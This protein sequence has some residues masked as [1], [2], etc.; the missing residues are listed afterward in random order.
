MYLKAIIYTIV[1]YIISFLTTY[2]STKFISNEVSAS[3]INCSYF[4]ELIFSTFYIVLL[5]PIL[6]YLLINLKTNRFKFIL[7]ML[8]TFI[9]TTLFNNYHLI[10]NWVFAWSTFTFKEEI[11]S[12]LLNSSI[13][14]IVGTIILYIFNIL[15]LKN[16]NNIFY[17]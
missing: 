14:V 11:L 9:V 3:C 12:I 15:Y 17:K 5:L 4:K 8:I 6:I 16:K 2:C 10:K 7:I 13:Y 1:F